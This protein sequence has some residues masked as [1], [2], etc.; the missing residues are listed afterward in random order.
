MTSTDMSVFAHSQQR[1]KIVT[2]ENSPARRLRPRFGKIPSALEY[3]GLSR[4]SLY[5]FAA[6]R[7]GLFRK[8]GSATVVDFDALDLLLDELPPAELKQPAPRKPSAGRS[9]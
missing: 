9:E 3:S 8:N 2:L 5:N 6:R 4:S 7:P 1:R